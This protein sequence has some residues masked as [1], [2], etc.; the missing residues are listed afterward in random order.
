MLRPHSES[1]HH[2]E[3]I[4][5]PVFIIVSRRLRQF[6]AD[7]SL[8]V[9]DWNNLRESQEGHF[10]EGMTAGIIGYPHAP[11]GKR[12][13]TKPKNACKAPGRVWQ[14]ARC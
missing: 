5:E 14:P 1:S 7:G 12:S 9:L 8:L 2:T 10:D 11:E 4:Y 3:K 13:R 6:L